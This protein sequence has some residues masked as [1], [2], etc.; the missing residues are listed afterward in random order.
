MIF[1]RAFVL[2]LSGATAVFGYP[3]M[4]HSPDA[5]LS[6]YTL[7]NI[8]WT[9]NITSYGTEMTFT[10]PTMQ[11]IETQIL[12]VNP[13]FSWES[14]G[15]SN[16]STLA[17]RKK[18]YVSCDPNGFWWAQAYRIREGMDYLSRITGWCHTPSRNCGRP[19][20][21]YHS[22]IYWCNDNDYP[23]DIPCE[24]WTEYT[25]DI[26]DKCLVDD[27]AQQV[28]GQAFDDDNWNIIVGWGDC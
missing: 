23:V 14:H 12:Q 24:F 9:G 5:L 26:L 15:G 13:S 22:A 1:T 4:L 3:Q 18:D 8:T 27:P 17:K 2:M 10:G 16:R 20:C 11:D 21:G 6:N 25:Q 19:S 28:K 7:G